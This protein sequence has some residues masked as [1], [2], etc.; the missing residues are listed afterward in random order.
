VVVEGEN[1]GVIMYQWALTEE[2][3]MIMNVMD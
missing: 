1:S 2:S 3:G